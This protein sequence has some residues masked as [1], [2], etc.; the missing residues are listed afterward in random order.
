M[1]GIINPVLKL[2]QKF[3]A[4]TIIGP[5]AEATAVDLLT[6]HDGPSNCLHGYAYAQ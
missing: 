4:G 5:S 1:A 2:S 6:E 3:M